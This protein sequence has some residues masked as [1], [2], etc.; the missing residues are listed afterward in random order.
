V[1]LFSASCAGLTCSFDAGASYDPDDELVGW[2]WDFGDGAAGSGT[3]VTHTFARAGSFAVSLTVTDD[4]DA[5]NTI[6]QMVAVGGTDNQPPLAAFTA[7][8]TALTCS[9]DGNTSSDPDGIVATWSWDLGDGTHASGPTVTRTYGAAGTFTVQLTVTD[10]GSSTATVAHTVTVTAPSAQFAAD[11]FART[12]TGGWGSAPT[13]GPWTVVG[14]ASRA[15]VTPGRATMLL[16]AGGQ[17]QCY[18][19]AVAQTSADV[20]TATS[21]DSLP[22]GGPVY[23]TVIARQVST[24]TRYSAVLLVYPAGY[25]TLRIT[26]MVGGVETALAGPVT[27]PG[28]VPRAAQAISIRVQAFGTSPTTVRARA[29]PASGAEPGTWLVS[30]TDTSAALQ[31][32]GSVGVLD[33]VSGALTNGPITVAYPSLTAG[34]ITG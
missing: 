28:L 26:R 23:S 24:T 7:A 21:L 9:F 2:G 19:G 8:C 15:S 29:W 33:Y 12:L 14:T 5:T 34:P 22:V 1:A 25:A 10:D 4:A 3:T 20:L 30:A 32:K 27:V 31:A 18:L 16:P 11:S 6:T 13:G 17:L